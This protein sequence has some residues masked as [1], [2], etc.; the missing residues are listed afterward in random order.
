A[1]KSELEGMI[2]DL[3]EKTA[4]TDFEAIKAGTEALTNK[5]SEI[6]TKLYQQAAAQ[7]QAQGQQ[8]QQA[9][10]NVVDTDYEVVDEDG[11]KQ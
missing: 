2:K 11:N 1:E 10:D 8:T 6:S 5:F 3:K 4:G 9:G 7:Q